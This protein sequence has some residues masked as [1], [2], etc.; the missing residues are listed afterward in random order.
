LGVHSAGFRPDGNEILPT[1]LLL[2]VIRQAEQQMVKES[3]KPR[4]GQT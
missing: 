4:G 2:S 3:Q 1:E